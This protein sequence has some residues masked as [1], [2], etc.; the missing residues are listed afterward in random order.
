M[1]PPPISQEG[2]FA[3]IQ[4]KA[5]LS[6]SV[7]TLVFGEKDKHRRFLRIDRSGVSPP[8]GNPNSMS[9]Y[10]TDWQKHPLLPNPKLLTN[11]NNN[12]KRKSIPPLK[13]QL[14]TPSLG[15]VPLWGEPR[16]NPAQREAPGGVC[17]EPQT[18]RL[19]ANSSSRG[20]AGSNRPRHPPA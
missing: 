7:L 12:N 20:C 11:N 17:A 1:G 8:E 3:G 14:H 19:S 16:K 18:C 15:D 13:T 6:L 5:F 2:K 10:A 9:V 4:Q